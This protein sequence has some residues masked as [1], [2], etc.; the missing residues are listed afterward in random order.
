MSMLEVLDHGELVSVSFDDLLKYHGRSS[1][2]GVAHGFKVMER[3]FPLLAGGSPPERYD[4]EIHSAFDG[5]GTRDAFEMVTRAVTGDRY[6]LALE[7]APVDAPHGP[8]GRFFFRFEY[9]GSGVDLKLRVGLVSDEFVQ[10]ARREAGTPAEVE[11]LAWLKQD[12]A[13]RLLS[14][15]ANE[16]YDASMS[17]L[18]ADS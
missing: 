5:A 6:R 9:R 18:D 3:A 4:I 14:L 15:E 11:H 17:H 12:M 8:E 7:L 16:V 10:L 2:A 13:D 1:I